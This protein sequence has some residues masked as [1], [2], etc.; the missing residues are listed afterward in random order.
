MLL[1]AKNNGDATVSCVEAAGKQ[2]AGET[3]GPLFYYDLKV[4]GVPV[5]SM[6]DCGS[7]TTIVSR[8]LLHRVAQ[9]HQCDGKPLPELKMSTVCLYGKDGPKGATQ[10]KVAAQMDLLFKANGEI[11]TLPVFVQPDS[12]QE[13]LLGTN[14]SVPLDFNFTDGNGKPLRTDPEPSPEPDVALVSLIKPATI[15]SRK[16]QFL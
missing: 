11:V 4:E 7:Q 16:G 5:V 2:Y 3:I 12:T 14:A 1:D 9:Q 8:Y 6:V 15:P 10:L 13:C